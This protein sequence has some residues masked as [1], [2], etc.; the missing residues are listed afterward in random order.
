MLDLSHDSSYIQTFF[1]ADGEGSVS[2]YMC[3]HALMETTTVFLEKKITAVGILSRKSE[4]V[5]ESLDIDSPE[6][7][8]QHN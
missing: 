2:V 5:Y 7:S 4:E 3:V 1:D 8:L 6:D